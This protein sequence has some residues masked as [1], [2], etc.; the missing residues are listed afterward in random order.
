MSHNKKIHVKN[1]REV[2]CWSYKRQTT[3]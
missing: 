1:H 2:H 3:Y